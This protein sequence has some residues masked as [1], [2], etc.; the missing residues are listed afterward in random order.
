MTV[1]PLEREGDRLRLCRSCVRPLFPEGFTDVVGALACPL[2]S[3]VEEVSAVSLL[4]FSGALDRERERFLDS[5]TKCATC[6]RPGRSLDITHDLTPDS[7]DAD[8]L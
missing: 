1:E 7:G 6:T 5:A 8:L 4:V 2:R 3:C